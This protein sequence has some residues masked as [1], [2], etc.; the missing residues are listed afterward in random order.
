M[1]IGYPNSSLFLILFKQKYWC[2]ESVQD[3]FGKQYSNPASRKHKQMTDCTRYR[4]NQVPSR[5]VSSRVTSRETLG[6]TLMPPT[7][8]L[9]PNH[10]F[11]VRESSTRSVTSPCSW[12]LELRGVQ[13]TLLDNGTICPSIGVSTG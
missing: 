5:R 4:Y 11:P 6:L 3:R 13:Y 1:A 7:P 12:L 2:S 8:L 9:N 10:A